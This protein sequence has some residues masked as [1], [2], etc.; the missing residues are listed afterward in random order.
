ME[1]GGEYLLQCVELQILEEGVALLVWCV[2]ASEAPYFGEWSRTFAPMHGA[3]NFEGWR[4]LL[5]VGLQDESFH[6]LGGRPG[7]SHSHS[8]VVRMLVIKNVV[9]GSIFGPV[10][11]STFLEN[12]V[13]FW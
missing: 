6:V 1:D 2:E 3:P 9:K 8:K 13:L 7:G 5:S 11:S 12:R 4:K 10:A